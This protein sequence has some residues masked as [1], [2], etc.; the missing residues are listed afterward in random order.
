MGGGLHLNS[1]ISNF[2]EIIKNYSIKDKK[3]L[4]Q[5]YRNKLNIL[6]EIQQ[7]PLAVVCTGMKIPNIEYKLDKSKQV[8]LN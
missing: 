2:K 4:L 3:L 7:L 8:T 6:S 5:S 1:V